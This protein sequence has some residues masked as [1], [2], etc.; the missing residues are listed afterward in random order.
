M[1]RKDAKGLVYQLATNEFVDQASLILRGRE[2]SFATCRV[3]P[4]GLNPFA[5]DGMLNFE[6]IGFR[7]S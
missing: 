3:L 5:A 2:R 7:V 4:R 1:D 6:I